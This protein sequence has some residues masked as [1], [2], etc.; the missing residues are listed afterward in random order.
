MK[1][2]AFGGIFFVYISVCVNHGLFILTHIY[3]KSSTNY[4]PLEELAQA[5]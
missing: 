5:K 1:N 4:A 3:V 2:P